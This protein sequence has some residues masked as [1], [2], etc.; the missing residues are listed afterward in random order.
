MLEIS[1]IPDGRLF[2]TKTRIWT[3]WADGKLNEGDIKV[4]R[5]VADELPPAFTDED[6]KSIRKLISIQQSN[7]TW[8]LPS[9]LMLMQ[10]VYFYCRA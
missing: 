3:L 2:M 5:R 8:K 4:L 10:P 6:K 9:T 1:A 7:L